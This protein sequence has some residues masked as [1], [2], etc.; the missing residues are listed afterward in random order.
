MSIPILLQT[1]IQPNLILLPHNLPQLPTNFPN[2]R[3]TPV[4]PSIKLLLVHIPLPQQHPLQF[5][6]GRIDKIPTYPAPVF[7]LFLFE[8]LFGEMALFC[9]GGFL[10]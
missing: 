10:G 3:P 5:K 4:T 1:P 2:I 8:G 6:I 9:F 7:Y